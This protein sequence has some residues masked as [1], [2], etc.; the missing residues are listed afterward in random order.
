MKPDM[1]HINLSKQYKSHAAEMRL[2]IPKIPTV[3]TKPSTALADPWPAPT[4]LPKISQQDNT[5]DYE[6]EMAIII[7]RSCKN[8]SSKDAL[9]YVLGYTAANDVSSRTSQ[10]NQS[11][12][13]FSKGFDTSCPIGPVIVPP[14]VMHEASHFRIKGIKNGRVLQDCGLTYV[15]SNPYTI[16][17]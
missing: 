2:D 9:Q 10:M 7:G 16:W 4:T 17:P 11:Q 5:G 13:C 8:V 6:A 15:L 12:W 3:F 1:R 14:S